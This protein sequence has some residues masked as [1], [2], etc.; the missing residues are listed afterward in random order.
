MENPLNRELVTTA[1][2]QKWIQGKA[3]PMIIDRKRYP[4][5]LTNLFDRSVVALTVSGSPSTRF[6]NRSRTGAIKTL[7]RGGHLKCK[8]IK[9]FRTY[10][11]RCCPPPPYW[12]GQNGGQLP[13]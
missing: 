6:A 4:L 8:K 2:P 5:A 11:R 12:A 7:S 10:T 9:G 13:R 3:E 1:P